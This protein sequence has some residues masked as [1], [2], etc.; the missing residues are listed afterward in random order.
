MPY[1]AETGAEAWDRLRA[2]PIVIEVVDFE[3]LSRRVSPTFVRRTTVVCLRSGNDEGFGE[4]V[5]WDADEQRALPAHG[6][7]L[8]LAGRL[9]LGSFCDL[10]AELDLFP[11][12]PRQAAHRLYRRWAFESAALDLALRQ[13]GRSLPDVLGRQPAPVRF[14]ASPSLGNPPSAVPIR[15]RLD[16]DPTL[17]FK[18][19]ASP[20]WDEELVQALAATNAVDVVDFKGAYH[21]T[22]VD[23][24]PDA[25]LYS[26]VARG[27]ESA[28]LEDPAWTAATRAALAP[29]LD[30]VTWDA[31]IH[32]V[33]DVRALDREPRMLNVKP[34]RIGSIHELLA[35]YDYCRERGIG[36]YGGGQFE[37][38]PGR[39]QALCLASLFHP[40]APNDL[41]PRSY[42]DPQPRAD[43]PRSPVRP[44]PDATGFRMPDE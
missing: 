17:R 21:G 20:A 5:D 33:N 30:R 9:T 42:H 41:A 15:R 28:W 1:T 38:G 19:D 40:D 8:P 29:F 12:P 3:P 35:V 4:D 7:T 14:V 18:L 25:E 43:L 26:R 32:S 13:A 44:E 27:L 11:E 23:R 10:V 34:S 37:L 16:L 39:G 24:A 36:M 2:L 31:P 6:R 22:D